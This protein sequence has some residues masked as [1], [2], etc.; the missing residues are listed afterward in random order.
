M[1]GQPIS[2]DLDRIAR[3]GSYQNRRFVLH[4]MYES[5]SEKS[6][7]PDFAE[8]LNGKVGKVDV[9]IQYSRSVSL[10]L[11]AAW[12]HEFYGSPV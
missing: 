11:T 5:P 4:G 8:Q 12:R 3:T 2:A 7:I 9:L 10:A 1:T 6:S